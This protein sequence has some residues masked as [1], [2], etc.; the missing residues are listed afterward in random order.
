MPHLDNFRPHMRS[1]TMSPTPSGPPSTASPH[2]ERLLIDGEL[3][4]AAGSGTFEVLNP[5]D[6]TVLGKVADAGREDMLDAIGAAR[7][8]F[9][10]TD[11]AVDRQFRKRAL[12]QLL[13]ALVEEKDML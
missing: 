2:E 5:A 6:G 9:E 3:R 11:W 8:A 1:Q 7:R 4:S 12:A 10:E 13:D